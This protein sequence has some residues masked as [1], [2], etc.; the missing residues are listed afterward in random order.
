MHLKAVHT[1]VAGRTASSGM[2]GAADAEFCTNALLI[3]G[4]M[5]PRCRKSRE[6]RPTI[7]RRSYLL[8]SPK[9]SLV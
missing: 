7:V 1:D 4:A 5:Q 6:G 2:I 8:L 3:Q 9:A